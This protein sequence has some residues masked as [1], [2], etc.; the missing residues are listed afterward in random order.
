MRN[1]FGTLIT[2]SL[3]GSGF[4]AT[5]DLGWIARRG[6]QLLEASTVPSEA[7]VTEAGPSE[8][9]SA[10]AAT[11]EFMA[12]QQPVGAGATLPASGAATLAPSLPDV[13]PEPTP[14]YAARPPAGGP[15]FVELANLESGTRLYV[16]TVAGPASGHPHRCLALDIVDPATGAALLH[17]GHEPPRRVTILPPATAGFFAASRSTGGGGAG[18]RIAVRSSF[19]VVPCG[20]AHAAGRQ[21]QPETIGPVVA[22]AFAPNH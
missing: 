7:A 3:L 2:L 19:S 18:S 10:Q 11:P 8:V 6:M 1:T 15:A 17:R 9:M 20:L 22:I 13:V 14:W 12:D 21:A 16:W 5:G 4:A